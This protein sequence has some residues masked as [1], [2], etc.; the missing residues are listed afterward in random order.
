MSNRHA[1]LVGAAGMKDRNRGLS[2][3]STLGASTDV[4]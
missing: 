4:Y 2:V 3:D 1:N